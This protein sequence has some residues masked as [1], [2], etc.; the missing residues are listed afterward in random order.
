MNDP[1][2][3]FMMSDL[4]IKDL[5]KSIHHNGNAPLPSA[6]TGNAHAFTN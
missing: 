2:H 5:K 6:K 3:Q 1:I 4:S